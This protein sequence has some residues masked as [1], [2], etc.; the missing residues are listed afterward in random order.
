MSI[1]RSCCRAKRTNVRQTSRFVE[2]RAYVDKLKSLSDKLRCIAV[3]R[4]IGAD[5]FQSQYRESALV[6]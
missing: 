6:K 1:D 5:R 3:R 2:V 4:R